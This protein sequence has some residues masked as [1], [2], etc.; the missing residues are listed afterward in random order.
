MTW[1]LMLPL[2][3]VVWLCDLERRRELKLTI[4][5]TRENDERWS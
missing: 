5:A 1:A 2:I 3:F 4:T